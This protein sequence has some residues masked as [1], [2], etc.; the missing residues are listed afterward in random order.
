MRITLIKTCQGWKLKK[1]VE[2]MVELVGIL[3]VEEKYIDMDYRVRAYPKNKEEIIACLEHTPDVIG[4]NTF[5]NRKWEYDKE[6]AG[7]TLFTG[8]PHDRSMMLEHLSGLVSEFRIE[9][10][11]PF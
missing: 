2:K 6:L 11:W 9:C 5:E 8:R 10:V 1:D 3:N 7:Y 4:C